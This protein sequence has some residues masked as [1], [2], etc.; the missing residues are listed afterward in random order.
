MPA[1]DLIDIEGDLNSETNKKED[2]TKYHEKRGF[3]ARNKGGHSIV[4]FV[5]TRDPILSKY[6]LSNDY[7]ISLHY[8]MDIIYSHKTPTFYHRY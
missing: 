3:K 4:N 6:G 1:D 7:P 8:T 2:K 5:V